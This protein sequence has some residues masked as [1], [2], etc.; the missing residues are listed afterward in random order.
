MHTVQHFLKRLS[1]LPSN[2]Q[3]CA[4][5]EMVFIYLKPE[6]CASNNF[7]FIEMLLIKDFGAVYKAS[8]CSK[9]QYSLLTKKLGFVCS[10]AQI[11]CCRSCAFRVS[12]PPSLWNCPAT[13]GGEC[14]SQKGTSFGGPQIPCTQHSHC[15][16]TWWILRRIAW[17][18]IFR[19][20]ALTIQT[21]S[22]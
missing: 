22:I 2:F 7:V 14:T 19:V 21:H 12:F 18:C 15:P 17:S 13:D 20:L 9:W 3:E 11:F 5:G 6:E 16:G 10:K 8:F 1:L 4:R